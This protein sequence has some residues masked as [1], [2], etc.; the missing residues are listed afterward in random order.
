MAKNEDK[1]L[2]VELLKK[3]YANRAANEAK[4]SFEEDVNRSGNYV[5]PTVTK[6]YVNGTEYDNLD[7]M[8]E[9]VRDN[10]SET[11][12]K[13]QEE[14]NTPQDLSHMFP[15]KERQL[16]KVVFWGGR[17]EGFEGP[18]LHVGKMMLTAIGVAVAVFFIYRYLLTH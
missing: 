14:S 2:Q 11:L 4:G 12:L 17:P 7:D 10:M 15:K 6:I 1:K 16:S 5:E 13:V 3:A 8:P 9:S 18:V